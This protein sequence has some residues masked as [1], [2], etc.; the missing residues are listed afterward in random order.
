MTDAFR[1]ALRLEGPADT[2]GWR[3]RSCTW[4]LASIVIT[5]GG[6]ALSAPFM[7]ISLARQ[8]IRHLEFARLPWP[9]MRISHSSGGIDPFVLFSIPRGSRLR[10]L[11]LEQDYEMASI[12]WIP[13]AWW[14]PRFNKQALGLNG[15]A[16][17]GGADRP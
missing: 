1:G 17:Q 14:N 4:P 10:A 9:A 8:D 16:E 2:T 6:F 7:A 3:R 12:C 15:Q 5:Q 11:L 13:A